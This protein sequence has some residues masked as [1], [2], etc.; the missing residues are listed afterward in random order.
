MARSQTIKLITDGAA[1]PSRIYLSPPHMSGAEEQ[2]VSD[3]FASNV[4][5]P[6]GPH[7]EAFEH[8]FA[9][10]VGAPQAV[11]VSSGTAALHLALR[12]VG[13][14]PGDEVLV[15]TLTFVASVN[16]ILYLGATPVFV[17]SERLS[18]NMDPTPSQARCRRPS[19]WSTSM[20]RVPTS[21]PSGT[22][23]VV[24]G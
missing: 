20:A 11:A 8:E 1:A 24:S 10:A 16:P 7:V 21:R 22:S 15:S 9:K 5:A 12:L 13:V 4:I 2:L 17:D 18:W 3:V 14:G 19:W 6:L 23:A